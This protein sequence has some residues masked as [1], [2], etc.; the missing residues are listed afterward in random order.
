[1]LFS[2]EEMVQSEEGLPNTLRWEKAHH[3]QVAPQSLGVAG[4]RIVVDTAEGTL[5]V[6]AE[7]AAFE[8]L[9]QQ[10]LAMTGIRG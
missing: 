8:H 4:H 5:I 6:L 2:P 10:R 9:A 1:M 7:V 3:A